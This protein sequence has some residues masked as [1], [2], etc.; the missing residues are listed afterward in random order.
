MTIDERTALQGLI[1]QWRS[2][3]Y[4]AAQYAN[5]LAEL[6]RKLTYRDIK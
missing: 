6:L 1:N 5:Q 3:G 4:D 2:E